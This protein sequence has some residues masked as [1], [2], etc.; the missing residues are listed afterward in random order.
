MI[1]GRHTETGIRDAVPLCAGVPL[2][3]ILGDITATTPVPQALPKGW[4]QK[5]S[6]F[7]KTSYD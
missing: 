6:L 3:K 2:P 4:E 5:V 7:L 1:G